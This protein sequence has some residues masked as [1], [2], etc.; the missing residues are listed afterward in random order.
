MTTRPGSATIAPCPVALQSA[1]RAAA[2]MCS[3]SLA[4]LTRAVAAGTAQQQGPFQPVRS[5]ALADRIPASMR[6]PD[7]NGFGIPSRDRVIVCN[8]AA[9]NP[10]DFPTYEMPA[11]A[12]NGGKRCARARAATP[13]T[14]P[15]SR[16]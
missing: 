6:G 13:T 11:G 4:L 2:A 10:A 15:S 16:H 7:G 3:A 1:M 14:C 9:A 5:N 8:E 12:K